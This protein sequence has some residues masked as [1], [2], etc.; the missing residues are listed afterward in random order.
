MACV[1]GLAPAQAPWSAMVGLVTDFRD[2]SG[3][4]HITRLVR[5]PRQGADRGAPVLPGYWR[6]AMAVRLCDD[7]ESP[8]RLVCRRNR[9]R[10]ATTP[11]AAE[12]RRGPVWAVVLRP[13]HLPAPGLQS[14]DYADRGP[15]GKKRPTGWPVVGLMAAKPSRSLPRRL[16]LAM[17]KQR[18]NSSIGRDIVAA[19]RPI[20]KDNDNSQRDQP[21]GCMHQPCPTLVAS[22]RSHGVISRWP[23]DK[24]G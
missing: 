21:T 4:P 1:S 19:T 20:T 16:G 10:L 13:W 23:H 8:L 14:S 11:R 5:R 24:H 6:S 3:P 17:S 22:R 18:A 7:A 15:A 2:A 12:P 9:N